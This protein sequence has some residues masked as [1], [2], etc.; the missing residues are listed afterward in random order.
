MVFG[1]FTMLPTLV[2][3]HPRP[4]KGCFVCLGKE[5]WHKFRVDET[6]IGWN[7]TINHWKLEGDK[8]L[9]V[10]GDGVND[11]MD[12]KNSLICLLQIMGNGIVIV[13]LYFNSAWH[14]FM[15]SSSWCWRNL[16]ECELLWGYCLEDITSYGTKS[17]IVYIWQYGC[18]LGQQN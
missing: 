11:Y 14:C 6:L 9:V 10:D 12:K 15:S 4:F 13:I 3:I 18:I 5:L 1:M 16:N 17:L 2:L 7:S 8:T